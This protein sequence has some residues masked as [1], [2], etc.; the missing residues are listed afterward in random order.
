MAAPMKAA[1]SG[2]G[3]GDEEERVP[4]A[5]PQ[6]SQDNLFVVFVLAHGTQRR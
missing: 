2:C 5:Q 1:K 3:S 4:A 6:I